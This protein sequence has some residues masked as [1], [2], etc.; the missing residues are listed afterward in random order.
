M[1][2]DKA[3]AT[4]AVKVSAPVTA[5]GET[6]RILKAVYGTSEPAYLRSAFNVRLLP[7]STAKTATLEVTLDYQK[8]GPGNS[9]GAYKLILEPPGGSKD[10]ELEV[11]LPEVKLFPVK[12]LQVRRTRF[13][14]ISFLESTSQKKLYL[15]AQE[16]PLHAVSIRQMG[17]SSRDNLPVDGR[18]EFKDAAFKKNGWSVEV[19]FEITG[20]F[21]VGNSVGTVAVSAPGLELTKVDFIVTTRWSSLLIFLLALAGIV[22]GWWLRTGIEAKLE[23]ERSRLQFLELKRQVRDARSLGIEDTFNETLDKIETA[24]DEILEALENPTGMEDSEALKTRFKDREDELRKAI[25]G[26]ETVRRQVEEGFASLRDHLISGWRLPAPLRVIVSNA[27]EQLE[28]IRDLFAQGRFSEA[29]KRLG[30]QWRHLEEKLREAFPAWHRAVEKGTG[31]L[32]G[33]LEYV[34]PA[35]AKTKLDQDLAAFEKQCEE[36]MPL[37]DTVSKDAVHSILNAAHSARH[38]AVEMFETLQDSVLTT[39]ADVWRTLKS[40]LSLLREDA[41]TDE[42]TLLETLKNAR[43]E[44]LEFSIIAAVDDPESQIPALAKWV[45]AVTQALR[46]AI[47][48]GAAGNE[49]T[50]NLNSGNYFE[51][52]V[53]KAEQKPEDE[54]GPL[55]GDKTVAV[56]GDAEKSLSF[57]LESITGRKARPLLPVQDVLTGKEQLTQPSGLKQPLAFEAALTR[58]EIRKTKRLQ[59]LASAAGLSVIS[60]VMFQGSF[61]GTWSDVITI[62]LWGFTTDVG[63]NVLM[64]KAKAAVKL[65]K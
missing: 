37:P 25:T 6:L 35:A 48:T 40:R 3:G 56:P 1:G 18:L 28:E 10:L 64:D 52:A 16:G 58:K 9:S 12:P 29:K 61:V 50:G 38:K 4:I 13:F 42:K 43:Q 5:G 39:A 19:P 63:V 22:A 11:L 47:E 54:S 41:L 53:L 27:K 62:F 8:L 33:S 2:Q 51:A 31:N 14:G 44:L 34:L 46:Q 21:P 15:D 60:W 55:L 45:G 30:E 49:V 65:K 32:P 26:L 24:V 57:N 17:T 59:L 36:G 7:G 23:R 20:S